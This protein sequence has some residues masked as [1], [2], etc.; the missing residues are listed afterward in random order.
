MQF[1]NMLIALY[2]R[3]SKD[4]SG[5]SEN[6]H[7]Q[8]QEGEE[9]VEDNGGTVSLRFNDD[10]ISASKFSTKPRP[11]YERLI[12][13]VERGEVE[14]IVVTE[15]TRLYRRLEELLDL[16]KMAERTKLRGIWTTDGIGYDLGTPEGIHAAI[17]AVNNAM[18]ESAKMSKRGKRKK[19][20]RAE[21][22]RYLGGTRAFGY[23]GARKD[24]HGN[25]LNRGRINVALV[26]HE[27]ELF[28]KCV[29]RAMAGEQVST[30]MYDL[31]DQGIPAPKGGQ[32]G[33]G[34]FKKCLIRKRY[35][36]FDDNDPEQ[37]GTMVYNGQEYRAVW[38][39]LITRRQH[40]LM[41]AQFAAAAAERKSYKRVHRR[42]Y[43]L[44]GIVYCGGCGRA[45]HG[46]SVVRDDGRKQ[47]SYRCRI[48]DHYGN[49]IG[50]G[51]VYRVA[52]PV[53]DFIVE[54]VLTRLDVPEVAQALSAQPEDDGVSAL[55]ETLAFRRKHRTNLVAE[56]GRGEHS[57]EDYKVMLAAA[58]EAIDTADAEVAKHLSNQTAAQLPTDRALRE[59]WQGASN[60]WRAEVI[61]LLVE[62]VVILPGR[63]GSHRYKE[64][65][66]NPAHIEIVWKLL[67]KHASL[68]AAA[69]ITTERKIRSMPPALGARPLMAVAA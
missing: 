46:S 31:N 29:A 34:N 50:C 1:Y 58:D 24:E 42:F 25:I 66:F 6:V 36:N 5:L 35:V 23:E 52:D 3:L 33:I 28:K 53:E 54:R 13:A 8:L 63:P 68:S 64:W 44:S 57:K 17:A 18:L 65:R 2:A 12:A 48:R 16:I 47:R 69:L 39:G 19:K 27:A 60:D 49:V 38:P 51:K 9:Y 32:W 61:K 7:I 4:R 15:M 56:Y 20:A 41:M 37:R 21:A 43:L 67:D 11:D 26:E 30:I 10:D 14:I 45:M 55:V 22:G 62:R 59:V 40:A